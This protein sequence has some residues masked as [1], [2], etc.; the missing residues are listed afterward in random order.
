M[1]PPA[2]CLNLGVPRCP[3]P[4][5]GILAVVPALQA[6]QLPLLFLV[7]PLQLCQL[8]TQLY[9]LRVQLVNGGLQW[10]HLVGRSTGACEPGQGLSE[11]QGMGSQPGCS[12][13]PLGHSTGQWGHR[14]CHSQA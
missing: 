10:A 7:A 3:P 11:G 4:G 12:G 8:H 14:A 2:E 13:V 9:L 6:G 5:W 1:E